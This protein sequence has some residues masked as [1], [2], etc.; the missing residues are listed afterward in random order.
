[1]CRS[2]ENE[3][4]NDIV[5]VLKN[6]KIPNSNISKQQKWAIKSLKEKDLV[7]LPADKGKAVV[8]FDREQYINKVETMLNED[9]STYKFLNNDPTCIYMRKIRWHFETSQSF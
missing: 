6:C 2:L 3:I 7:I 1:M 9:S 4:C 8:I 5:H